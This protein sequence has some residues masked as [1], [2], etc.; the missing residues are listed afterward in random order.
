MALASPDVARCMWIGGQASSAALFK[1]R[2]SKQHN[3]QA[4]ADACNAQLLPRT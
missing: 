1:T 3:H 4:R 2:G